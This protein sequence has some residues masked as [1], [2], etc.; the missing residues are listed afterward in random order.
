M[1]RA[2]F[3]LPL[4]LA[5]LLLTGCNQGDAIDP[6][7]HQAL[8]TRVQTL[9]VENENLREQLAEARSSSSGG[10]TAG[11]EVSGTP[12][13]PAVLFNSG[14]AWLTDRAKR[15][16]DDIASRLGSTYSGRP[17]AVQGHTDSVP[18]GDSLQTIYPTNWDL[19]A[20][21]AAA[22]A[23]YLQLRH[24]IVAQALAVA[25]ANDL[26]PV[27]SNETVDGRRQNRRVQVYVQ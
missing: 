3:F 12:L 7:E 17:V 10:T 5:G 11:G 1:H 22:V 18:I 21:R 2:R 15:Q 8:Q 19:S 6:E 23:R 26:R 24:G 4:L 14:S 20:A 25:A 27:A 16:L 9:E 13:E